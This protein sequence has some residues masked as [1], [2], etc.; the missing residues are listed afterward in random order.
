M[1]MKLG[2]DV[3][4]VGVDGLGTDAQTGSEFFVGESFA[5]EVED[6]HLAL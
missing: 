1:D 6:F 4:E 5:Q 3:F 2:I